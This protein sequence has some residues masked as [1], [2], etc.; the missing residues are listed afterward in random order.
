MTPEDRNELDA[1]LHQLIAEGKVR[2]FFDPEKRE[3][4]FVTVEHLEKPN[5]ADTR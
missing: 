3:L 5:H 2:T 1:A 4:V